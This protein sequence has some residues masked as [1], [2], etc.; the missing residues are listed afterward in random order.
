MSDQDQSTEP[1]RL[2]ELNSPDTALRLAAIQQLASG[3]ASKESVRTLERMALSDQDPQV[4]Q[5]AAQALAEPQLQSVQ[6]DLAQVSLTGRQFMLREIDMLEN[7][8]LVSS[9]QAGLI[10]GRY[11]LPGATQPPPAQT[12]G[13]KQP[14]PSLS[15]IL[16]SETSV[17]IALFLGAFFVVAAAFILAAVIEVARLPILGVTTLVFLGAAAGLSRRLPLASFVLF[18]VGALMIPID[19]GVMANQLKL[20]AEIRDFYWAG[21]AALD[22]AIWIFGTRLYRSRLFS[23]LAFLS[24]GLAWILLLL[25]LG[26]D[27]W[28]P[29]AFLALGLAGLVGLPAADLLVKGLGERDRQKTFFWPP[30]IFVQTWQVMVLGSSAIWLM[31]GWLVD[32]T[33]PHSTE[34]LRIA[35]LWGIGALFYA[36][37]D[38]IVQRDGIV[39]PFGLPMAVCLMVTPLFALGFLT[40]SFQLV[41]AVAWIWGALLI[42]TAEWVGD[43]SLR[44]A[45]HTGMGHAPFLFAVGGILVLFAAVAEM[46]E[47]HTSPAIGYLLVSALVFTLLTIRRVRWVFW[48]GALI[49]LYLAYLLLFSLPVLALRQVFPGFILLLP[50]LVLLAIDL[51]ARVR[52][53]DPEWSSPAFFLGVLSGLFG[54]VI[55]IVSGVD[56]PWNAALVFLVYTLFLALFAWLGHQPKAIYI[57]ACGL[58]LALGFIL[59]AIEAKVWVIPLIG[60]AVLYELGGLALR[61]LRAKVPWADVLQI[62]GLV[63]AGAIALTAPLEGG[64]AAVLGVAIS[65]TLFTFE[66]LR[67][68]NVWLGFPACLLYFLAYALALLEL[69]LRQPQLY[70]IAA[71]LLGILMHYLLIRTRNASAALATGLLSQL[72]LLSTTYIQ[73]LDSQD[74]QFFFIIFFQALALEVYGLV[75]RSRSFVLLPVAFLVLSVVTVAFTVL[76]GLPTVLI[77]GCTGLLLLGLGILALLLRERLAMVTDRWVGRLDNW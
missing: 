62:S 51:A 45:L 42:A 16:L 34:W 24:L 23:I 12:S 65:A 44:K 57:A 3:S 4:R 21:I 39:I 33:S 27:L 54:W 41:M 32:G 59:I 53:L 68:R 15:Q 37:S 29:A 60:L 47:Q 69:D 22:G 74:F 49:C 11:A 55:A 43:R 17:R 25:A 31:A 77:I 73:M 46:I 76:S 28:S 18:A 48:T 67:L 10:R 70:T 35:A 64:P 1:S 58:A 71:A 5:A 19:A 30:F 63:L 20:S 13:E 36:W 61:R 38:R 66:G 2:E 14:A 72:I 9:L 52:S 50:T 75:V 40:P 8:G 26:F 6:R 56:Q 7:D